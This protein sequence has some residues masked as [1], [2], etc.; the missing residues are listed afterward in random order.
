MEMPR[1]WGKLVS[2]TVYSGLK[3]L[4]T[5]G[6]CG[7]GVEF[8]SFGLL[9]NLFSLKAKRCLFKAEITTLTF[10]KGSIVFI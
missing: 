1:P 5:Q 10:L 9:S 6:C 2:P 3:D 4:L 8:C 7:K